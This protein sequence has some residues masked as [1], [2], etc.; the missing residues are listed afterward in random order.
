[1]HKVKNYDFFFNICIFIKFLL[2]YASIGI[3]K[4]FFQDYEQTEDLTQNGLDLSPGPS[5]LPQ[6]SPESQTASPSQSS[7][8]IPPENQRITRGCK[9]QIFFYKFEY[10]YKLII[11]IAYT[12]TF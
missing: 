12:R 1:M 6:D 11:C 4:L 9:K 3:L 5:P 10:R 7:S 2:L 8:I